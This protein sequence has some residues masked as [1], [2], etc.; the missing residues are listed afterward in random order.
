[1]QYYCQKVIAAEPISNEFRG[2][3]L[4]RTLIGFCPLLKTPGMLTTGHVEQTTQSCKQSWVRQQ[5]CCSW[6]DNLV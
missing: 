2:Q 1:M 5:Q 4:G 6:G 3:G